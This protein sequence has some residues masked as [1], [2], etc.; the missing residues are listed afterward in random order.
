MAVIAEAYVLGVSTRRVDE[1]VQTLGITGMSKSQVSELAK[2]LDDGVARFR[3]RPLDGGPYR[4]LQADALALKVREGGRIVQAAAL[5]AT[6]VNAD[7][8]REI[9]GF[10]VVT[11]EDGP[12][13]SASFVA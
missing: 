13:G 11:A 1:L 6:G 7:G 2:S 9:V 4:H 3:S 8:R 12:P 5:L 10:D